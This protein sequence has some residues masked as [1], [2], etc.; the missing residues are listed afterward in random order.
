MLRVPRRHPPCNARLLPLKHHQLGVGA[1]I[2]KPAVEDQ[3]VVQLAQIRGGERQVAGGQ[4]ALGRGCHGGARLTP[5]GQRQP[6]LLVEPL[7]GVFIQRHTALAKNRAQLSLM[8]QASGAC[9]FLNPD[10]TCC[11]YTARPQQCRDFPH[12][13][14]VAGC[15]AVA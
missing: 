12:G 9:C 7:I 6:G 15:P 1:R 14:R 11:V 13:W 2:T 8:E 10:N 5:C 3:R 4:T